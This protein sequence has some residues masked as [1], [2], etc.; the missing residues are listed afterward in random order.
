M[1]AW[2]GHKVTRYL[3]KHYSKCFCELKSKLESRKASSLMTKIF[4]E[5]QCWVRLWLA[6]PNFLKKGRVKS[7]AIALCFAFLK[8]LCLSPS[9]KTFAVFE[10]SLGR[11]LKSLAENL[12]R[13]DLHSWQP[14]GLRRNMWNLLIYMPWET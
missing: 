7:A 4:A 9:L 2:L 5:F 11:K 10:G 13:A 14:S 1:S 3:V 12:W 6:G 8:N